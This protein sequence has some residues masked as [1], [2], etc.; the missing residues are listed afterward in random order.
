MIRIREPVQAREN[1]DNETDTDDENEI[2]VEHPRPPR[3]RRYNL[4][5]RPHRFRE[6]RLIYANGE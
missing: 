6:P 1:D 4:R 3:G 5:N 2:I